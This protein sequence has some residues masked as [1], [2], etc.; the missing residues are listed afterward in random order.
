MFTLAACVS[1]IS[2]INFNVSSFR[3]RLHNDSIVLSFSST[4]LTSQVSV[5]LGFG[6]LKLKMPLRSLLTRV[7]SHSVAIYNYCRP[8]I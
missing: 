8:S 6:G 3:G 2:M 4:N 7:I 1:A 5:Y